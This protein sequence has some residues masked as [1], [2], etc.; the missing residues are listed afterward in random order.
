MRDTFERVLGRRIMRQV[1]ENPAANSVFL[2]RPKRSGLFLLH[3]LLSSGNTIADSKGFYHSEKIR[4]DKFILLHL[5]LIGRIAKARREN[6]MDLRQD[7][8]IRC[9]Q[10]IV[11]TTFTLA[12]VVCVY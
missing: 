4:Q 11:Q 6:S 3:D 12:M 9:G 1:I 5:R 10:V 8:F 7:I 2:P